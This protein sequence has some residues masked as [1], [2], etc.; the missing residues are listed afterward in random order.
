MR[1]S[2]SFGLIRINRSDSKSDKVRN[3][4]E[5]STVESAEPS[6]KP[7]PVVADGSSHDFDADGIPEHHAVH[8]I[9]PVSHSARD[10]D[11]HY[12]VVVDS[13]VAISRILG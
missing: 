12:L 7:F 11:P 10:C 4:D 1:D 5:S 6:S 3:V 13:A 2:L 9:S 8:L